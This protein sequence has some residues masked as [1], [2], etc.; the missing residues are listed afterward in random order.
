MPFLDRGQ[1]RIAAIGYIAAFALSMLLW[2]KFGAHM[3][4]TSC[5]E[6]FYPMFIKTEKGG[7]KCDRCVALSSSAQKTTIIGPKDKIR[8]T[9]REY[10]A[11]RRDAANRLNMALPGVGSVWYGSHI[12]GAILVSVT[13]IFTA[14][15]F[16]ALFNAAAGYRPESIAVY[17]AWGVAAFLFYAITAPFSMRRK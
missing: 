2:G 7:V 1:Y 3:H 16:T 11:G 13:G 4:C 5:G 15:A 12:A 10:H 14:R 9:I 17:S 6:T 8:A